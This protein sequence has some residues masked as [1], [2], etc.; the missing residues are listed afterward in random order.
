[1]IAFSTPVETVTNIAIWKVGAAVGHSGGGGGGGG[2]SGKEE[3]RKEEADL[4]RAEV[5]WRSRVTL[6]KNTPS[7]RSCHM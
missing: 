5:E 4:R 6:S 2:R 7:V 1:M 3:G